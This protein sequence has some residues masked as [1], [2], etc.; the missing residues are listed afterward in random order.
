MASTSDPTADSKSV[1]AQIKSHDGRDNGASAG[2]DGPQDVR[3]A[4]DAS[5]N[6]S[7][8]LALQDVDP[9]MNMKMHLVNNVS[10]L[11]AA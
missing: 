11:L 9:A 8:V 4:E 10:G 1:E 6:G 7:D 3:N 2:I 5:L